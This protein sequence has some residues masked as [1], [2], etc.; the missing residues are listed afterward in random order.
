[1]DKQTAKN[2]KELKQKAQELK[3]EE[4]QK[5]LEEK[6]AIKEEKERRKILWKKSKKLLLN[7]YTCNNTSISWILFGKQYLSKKETELTNKKMSQIYQSALSL[8]DD[9]NYKEAIELLK[10]IDENYSNFSDVKDKLKEVE[11]SYLN[12]Y[13]TEA[14]KYL[15][16]KKYDKAL[17]ILENIDKELQDYELIKNKKVEIKINKLKAEVEELETKKE[18]NIA[19]LEY[20]ST[21]DDEKNSELKNA[22][23]E[24]IT[25]YKSA[26]LL[27][28]RLLMK[29]DYAK[30]KQL[31]KKAE[32]LLPKDTD[33]KKLIEEFNKIE[34]TAINL[35]SLA[36]QNKE[37]KLI[38]STQN[39]K[40]SSAK[41]NTEYTNYI[42][43]PASKEGSTTKTPY[44]IEFD[45]NKEYTE[46]KGII[47]MQ[48]KDSEKIE[49]T[50]TPK[51]TFYNG[52]KAIYYTENVNDSTFSIDVKDVDKLIIE[53]EGTTTESY[54][55]ANPE[56]TPI[57]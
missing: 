45:L 46:L 41:T 25:K 35:L 49:N 16:D 52:S 17:E 18:G 27:E 34:P 11:Q 4:K 47:C 8:I 26:F 21:Y 6:K 43:K 57:K 54:F 24:L 30:A 33:I 20:I 7:N 22:K 39:D 13:L 19:I 37:D 14:D 5:R 42:L 23:E 10:S 53:F 28:T 44:T 2:K 29:T 32:E 48:T 36:S 40:I 12:E 1:M 51:V 55:I 56:L 38:L 3:I 31:I 15:K 50:Y 9:K